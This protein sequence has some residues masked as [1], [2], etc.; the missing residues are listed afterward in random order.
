M[1]KN[2]YWSDLVYQLTPYTPGEQPKDRLLLKLNTNE[3][4]YGPSPLVIDAIKN[5]TGDN[6]RLYPDPESDL[7]KQALADYYDIPKSFVFVGNGSDEVLAFI[8]QSLLKKNL[9]ILFPDI[10]YSFYPTYCS[11]YGIQY[12]TISLDKNFNINLNDYLYENG[13]VIFPNPNAPTAIPKSFFDIDE[14]YVDF[15][16]ESAVKL[17][18]KYDNLVITQSFSKSRSL[19]GLRLGC[20]LAHEELIQALVRVKDSFN[21]YS[22]D[23]LGQEAGIAAIKDSNFFLKTRNAIIEAREFLMRELSKMNFKILPSAANFIFT[24]H[25]KV[26]AEELFN[27]LRDVGILVRHFNKPKRITQYLR[28]TIGTMEEMK[29]LVLILKKILE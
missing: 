25:N 13:G 26:D 23:R 28:I 3:N 1:N 10:T 19:A 29:Q 6:L 8:F 4:P 15:G 12:D 14:A 27:K 2:K 24:K 5:V 16:T 21:S 9:P 18:K 11:L 22:V 7:L 17:I 20:A